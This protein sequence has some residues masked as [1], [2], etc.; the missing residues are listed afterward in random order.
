MVLMLV[1]REQPK[2][3]VLHD[4]ITETTLSAARL[5]NQAY[6][7]TPRP[8]PVMLARFQEER[9]KCLQIQV[10]DCISCVT[11]HYSSLAQKLN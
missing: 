3:A 7:P 10:Q 8:L 5:G 2:H 6:D 1:S 4:I 11:R 9:K